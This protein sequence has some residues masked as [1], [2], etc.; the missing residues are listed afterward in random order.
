MKS[1]LIAF[2]PILILW[3]IGMKAILLSYEIDS[4]LAIL[5]LGAFGPVLV[6][7]TSKWIPFSVR[8]TQSR[9]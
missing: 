4:V 2:G 7:V 8:K 9:S 5:L 6:L 1:L 3:A